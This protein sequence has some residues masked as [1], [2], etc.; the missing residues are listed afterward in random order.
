MVCFATLCILVITAILTG[1]LASRVVF[2]YV[3]F[4]E[5]GW[6]DRPVSYV[7]E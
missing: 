4:D 2:S 1:F 3:L 5:K 7:P 6:F